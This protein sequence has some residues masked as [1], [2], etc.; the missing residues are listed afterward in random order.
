[1]YYSPLPMPLIELNFDDNSGSSVLNSGSVPVAFK[2]TDTPS[3][4]TNIPGSNGSSLD[5]G[6]NHGNHYIESDKVVKELKGLT[7]F[8]VTGWVNV[9]S[10]KVGSGGNRIVSWI[11]NGGDGVDIIYEANGSLKVGINEWPDNT[12]A[13]STS[14]KL[15]ADGNASVS[16]WVFFAVT[17]DSNS[18]NLAFYFGDRTNPAELDK[19][20]SYKKGVV[21][22][23]IG[24]LAIGHFNEESRRSSRTNRMFRGLIDEVRIFGSVLNANEFQAIQQSNL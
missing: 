14:G 20:V 15:S 10:N 3:W 8:T 12:I 1:M 5:F 7:S 17:Y 16:N 13:V 24:K 18:N 22:T 2:K 21:G 23:D 9:R 4:S 19:S 11:N 6:T